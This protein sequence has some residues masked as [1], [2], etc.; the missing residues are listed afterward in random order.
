MYDKLVG[1]EK[2]IPF[3]NVHPTEQLPALQHSL[4]HVLQ[5]TTNLGDSTYLDIPVFIFQKHRFHIYSFYSVSTLHLD[6]LINIPC[7]PRM[8]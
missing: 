6:S 7:Q 8:S 5:I 3:R 1:R 2:L 4:D